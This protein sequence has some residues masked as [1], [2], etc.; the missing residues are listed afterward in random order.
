MAQGLRHHFL[1]LDAFRGIAA[2]CVAFFHI[3]AY[4]ETG[5][6]AWE[7]FHH[8]NI[9]VP[10][11]FTLSGFVLAY[12]Y[13]CAFAFKSFMLKRIF[14]IYPLHIFALALTIAPVVVKMLIH[15][16]KPAVIFGV[17]IATYKLTLPNFITNLTL[18]Q[19]ITPY[20]PH[21]TL[22][23]TSW[24]ISVE[25]GLY[26]IFAVIFALS[27]LTVRHKRAVKVGLLATL[28]FIATFAG[29]GAVTSP[30]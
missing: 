4:D 22:N 9:F 19:N 30:I 7:F 20:L 5:I 15:L 14:R 25:M 16:V 11:F 28:L 24:S 12:T 2:T 26:L 21:Y 6:G 10:F 23:T 29:G 17:P 8:S 13:D 1:S 18:T 3:S 27:L